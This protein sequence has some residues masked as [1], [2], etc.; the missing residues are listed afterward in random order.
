MSNK[1]LT[2]KKYKAI[3]LEFQKWE[4]KKYKGVRIYTER[5]ILKILSEKF[6][7]APKTIEN[8]IYYRLKSKREQ[9]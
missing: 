6:Y 9:E 3:R 1:E 2:Q 5:Y 4:E 7:L 8:I